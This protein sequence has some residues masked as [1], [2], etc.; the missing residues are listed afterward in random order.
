[1]KILFRYCFAFAHLISYLRSYCMIRF[2]LIPIS[3]LFLLTLTSFQ[4]KEQRLF[5]EQE[6]EQQSQGISEIDFS[7]THSLLTLVTK[8]FLRDNIWKEY[9]QYELTYDTLLRVNGALETDSNNVRT[10]ISYHYDQEGRVVDNRG[11]RWFDS[12]G[13]WVLTTTLSY[14]YNRSEERR[15]G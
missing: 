7:E 5:T 14:Q 8:S 13:A 11:E 15:V 6:D 3:T 1:M 4:L 10:R 12:A 2:S 9:Y